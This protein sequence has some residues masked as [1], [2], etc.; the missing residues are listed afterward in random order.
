MYPANSFVSISTLRLAQ[1]ASIK[2]WV[3]SC[4]IVWRSNAAFGPRAVAASK[5]AVRYAPTP[6]SSSHSD[7]ALRPSRSGPFGPDSLGPT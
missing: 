7:S 6:R 4:T 2:V 3:A 1:V 5:G